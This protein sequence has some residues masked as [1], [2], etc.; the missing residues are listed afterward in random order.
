MTPTVETTDTWVIATCGAPRTVRTLAEETRDG[1]T[2]QLSDQ[3]NPRS[4]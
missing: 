2:K 3:D 1:K 4:V